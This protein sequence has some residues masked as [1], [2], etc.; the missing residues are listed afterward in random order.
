MARSANEAAEQATILVVEDEVAIRLMIA[1]E[2]RMAGFR[3][4]EAANADEGLSVL[5]TIERVDLMITDVRMPG[6]I[7]GLGLADRVR[8]NWPAI[9]IIVASAHPSECNGRGDAFFDKPYDPASV[10]LRTKQLL[11]R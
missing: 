11:S 6:S 2:L 1:D 9:K 10:V 3:V 8:A 4:I 5:Q 7:D